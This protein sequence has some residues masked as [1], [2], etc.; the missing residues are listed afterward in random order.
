MCLRERSTRAR[1]RHGVRRSAHSEAP[2]VETYLWCPT[3]GRIICRSLFTECIKYRLARGRDNAGAHYYAV[4]ADARLRRA[5]ISSGF[6]PNTSSH[7]CGTNT[8]M[9]A[10]LPK[11]STIMHLPLPPGNDAIAES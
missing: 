1:K 11:R 9:I 3:G 10:G 6:V 8:S 5:R 2:P 7:A 4:R